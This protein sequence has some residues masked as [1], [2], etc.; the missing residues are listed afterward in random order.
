[1]VR[2]KKID[3]LQKNWVAGWA[4]HLQSLRLRKSFTPKFTHHNI[5][6][7]KMLVSYINKNNITAKMKIR[8]LN[9]TNLISSNLKVTHVDT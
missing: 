8:E 7:W 9:K 4:T 2:N 3:S 1:M 6:A 5:T